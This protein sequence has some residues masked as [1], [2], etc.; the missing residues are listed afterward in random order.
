MSNDIHEL[1]AEV[2]P[3]IHAA[4]VAMEDAVVA[5]ANLMAGAVAKRRQAGIMPAAAQPTVLM[6]HRAL[7]QAIEGG[8]TVLRVHG[9]LEDQ[10]R[11]LASDDIHPLSEDAVRGQANGLRRRRTEPLTLVG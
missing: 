11:V 5:I 6:L 9:K 3:L 2:S 7:S 1:A 4:E 10:Y 8:S